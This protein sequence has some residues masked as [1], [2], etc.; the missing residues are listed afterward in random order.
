MPVTVAVTAPLF[1][2]QVGLTKE[3]ATTAIGE[4]TVTLAVVVAVQPMPSLTVM[5]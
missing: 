5:V 2:P 1:E 4:V 3:F